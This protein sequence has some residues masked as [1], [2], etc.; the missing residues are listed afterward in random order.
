LQRILAIVPTIPISPAND[1][2]KAIPL[3]EYENNNG[4]DPV[5]ILNRTC[6]GRFSRTARLYLAV[7]ARRK[8]SLK[9]CYSF[10]QHINPQKA[11]QKPKIRK[12]KTKPKMQVP[13]GN[14][15]T[16]VLIITR[17]F[18]PLFGG[19]VSVINTKKHKTTNF[20]QPKNNKEK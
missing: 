13:I 2:S 8:S 7:K 9:T 3:T 5:E 12:S 4:P 10:G 1:Q 18:N 16:P 20:D 14:A 17:R 6:C 11:K 15:K 19:M